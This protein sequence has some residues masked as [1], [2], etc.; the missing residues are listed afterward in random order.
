[1]LYIKSLRENAGL[2]QLE[3]AKALHINSQATISMWET[4]ARYPK[5]E[6]LPKLATV[7][8]CTIDEIFFGKTEEASR[9]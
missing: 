8:N 3:L 7:L 6:N 5:T 1:M 4:G 2:T 9:R